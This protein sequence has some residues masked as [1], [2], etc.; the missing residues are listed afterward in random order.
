[1]IDRLKERLTDGKEKTKTQPHKTSQKEIVTKTTQN[2]EKET[3]QEAA[4]LHHKRDPQK[5]HACT[6]NK[7]EQR[8]AP[9]S[10]EAWELVSDSC[11]DSFDCCKLE[12]LVKRDDRVNKIC[13]TKHMRWNLQLGGPWRPR[14]KLRSMISILII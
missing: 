3:V 13:N 10:S 9:L 14:I 5:H 2:L 11:D 7:N 6:K 8:F 12:K 4:Y 1:M